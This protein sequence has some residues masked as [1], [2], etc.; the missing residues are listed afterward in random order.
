MNAELAQL[1]WLRDQNIYALALTA[2]VLCG[3]LVLGRRYAAARHVLGSLAMVLSVMVLLL[4]AFE[5]R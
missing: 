5:P 4:G 2:L 1:L 3:L